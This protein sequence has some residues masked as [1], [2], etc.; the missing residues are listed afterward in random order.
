MALMREPWNLLDGHL[1]DLQAL[2]GNLAWPFTILVAWLAGEYVHRWA[3]LPRISV[4]AIVG[5]LFASPQLGILP[6]SSDAV[7]LLANIAFGLIVFEAGHRLNWHWFRSN[8]WIGMSSLAES[9]LTFAAVFLLLRWFDLPLTTVCLF[10]ALAMATSPATVVR[11][12]NEQRSSGQV[13]ERALHLSVLDCVLAVFVFKVVVGMVV[14][15]S[16]G[17]IWQAAYGSLVDLCASFV[18]G[19][20]FG[21]AMPAL[22]RAISRTSQ[23]STLAFAIAVIFVVALTHHLRLSPILATLTFGLVARHRRIVLNPSQ[24][25][26]GA[27]GDLLCVL[28]FVYVATTLELQQ[29][30]AGIGLGFAIIAARQAAK[31]AGIVA[32]AHVSGITWRKGLL[33]GVAMTPISAF[34]ILVL[35]QTRSLGI[36][37]VDQLAPLAAAALVL[38]VVG[39]ILTQ[40]AFIWAR[41]VPE[42]E[43]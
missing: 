32:F 29:V 13:T 30:V 33:I 35:E 5:F 39:P 23:D 14:F 36:N 18:L 11:V 28:L 26:F 24:R 38:E 22:L 34:V 17:S 12:I 40:R 27:L 7:L 37:L 16:S 8:P 9:A 25:G 20:A 10:A 1:F 42:S 3:G 15:Q 6:A 43:L 31:M 2:T 41:E 21:I 4:Y 19:A